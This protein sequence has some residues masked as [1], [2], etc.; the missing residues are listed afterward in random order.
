MPLEIGVP[1]MT[2]TVDYHK[3]VPI[4]SFVGIAFEIG[5]KALKYM[6]EEVNWKLW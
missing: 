1:A 6:L 3:K 5:R 4:T 2:A